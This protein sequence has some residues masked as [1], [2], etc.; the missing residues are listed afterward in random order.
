MQDQQKDPELVRQLFQNLAR[1]HCLDVP[2]KKNTNWKTKLMEKSLDEAFKKFPL[3]KEIEQFNCET[4][5]N[6][7]LRA[8]MKWCEGVLAKVNS[9]IILCHND[10][11]SSNLMV[12]EPN[13]ELVVCDF[14]YGGYG[15]RG[16]TLGS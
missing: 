10:F 15:H 13:N 1:I 6:N 7:D 5:K 9:P 2:V 4:L 11:R 16:G 12:T 8:E 3:E 14:E